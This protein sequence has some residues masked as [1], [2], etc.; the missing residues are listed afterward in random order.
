MKKLKFYGLHLLLFTVL[1]AAIYF[2]LIPILILDLDNVGGSYWII[3][4]FIGYFPAIAIFITMLFFWKDGSW[5][6]TIFSKL[7]MLMLGFP[8]PIKKTVFSYFVVLTL[9][10]PISWGCLFGLHFLNS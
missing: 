6:N 9:G 8:V 3:M 7:V 1:W 2:Y 4:F 10:F 5:E